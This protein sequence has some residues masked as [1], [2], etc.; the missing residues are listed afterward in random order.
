MVGDTHVR[1]G[2]GETQGEAPTPE[3]TSLFTTGRPMT[4]TMTLTLGETVGPRV[5]ETVVGPPT[6]RQDF[7]FTPLG[8]YEVPTTVAPVGTES[9]V[10]R[11]FNNFI[12]ND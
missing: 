9:D 1:R 4:R 7:P 10:I 6:V 5:Q 3:S 11:T 12:Y 8:R 2:P